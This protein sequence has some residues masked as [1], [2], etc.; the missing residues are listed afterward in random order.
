SNLY[1]SFTQMLSTTHYNNDLY[2]TGRYGYVMNG[3]FIGNL[4][5]TKYNPQGQVEWEQIFSEQNGNEAEGIVA[6]VNSQGEV[7][8][9][10]IPSVFESTHVV[11]VKKYTNAGNLVWETEKDVH[12]ALLRAFFLDDNDNIYIAGSSKENVSDLTPKFTLM[13]YSDSGA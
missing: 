7:I 3:E 4:I 6:K 12:N 1:G 11:R 10:L 5:L 9:F 13:K 8:V 2:V